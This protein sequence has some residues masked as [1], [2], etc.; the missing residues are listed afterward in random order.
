MFLLAFTKAFFEKWV[1]TFLGECTSSECIFYRTPGPWV[2]SKDSS[3]EARTLFFFFL[4]FF[5]P[6]VCVDFS[7]TNYFWPEKESYVRY[8][9]LRWEKK[10]P[11][12]T[13][14]LIVSSQ[15]VTSRRSYFVGQVF[16]YTLPTVW[17]TEND[18]MVQLKIWGK[19]FRVRCS[20]CIK[21]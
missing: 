7:V 9:H 6:S 3:D 12:P 5:L 18:N 15:N 8:G 1:E 14:T 19:S 13:G 17:T 11:L 21:Q 16:H 10:S 2:F 20:F 4:F